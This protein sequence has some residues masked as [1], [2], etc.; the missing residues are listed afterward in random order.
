VPFEDVAAAKQTMRRRIIDTRKSLASDQLDAHAAGL[1]EQTLAL[2][3][4]AA[5]R[6]VAAYY[7]IDHEPGT[8]RLLAALLDSDRRLLLPVV[9]DDLDLD[10]AEL[11]DLDDLAAARMGLR[12]P[13]GERLG[14]DAIAAAD[15][16]LCPGLAVDARGVRLGRG[17]GCYDRALTHLGSGALRCILVYDHEVVE[18]V[19]S[20]RDDEPVD[21]AITPTRTMR[22]GSDTP[23]SGILRRGRRG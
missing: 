18:S 10:W 16:V 9:T 4:L 1:A 7:S 14:L 13:T 17:A 19:P 22:L 2:P 11:T 8:R 12:E 6:T 3:E 5:A 15:V 21:V 23:A 20:D